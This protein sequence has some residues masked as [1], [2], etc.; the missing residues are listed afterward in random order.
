MKQLNLKPCTHEPNLYFTDDY[1]G[2]GKRVLFLRQVDDF[3]IA[4]QDTDL[5]NQVIKDINSKMSIEVKHLGQVERFNGVDIDQRRE[6]VKIHNTTYIDKLIQQ[7]KWLQDDTGTSHHHP[8]PMNPS[9]QYI[10]ELESAQPLTT[11]EKQQL[12]KSLN[13]GYR[14]AVGEIIYAMITCRPDISFAIIKLSQYSARPAKIHYDALISLYQYLKHTKTDGIYYWRKRPRMDLQ[15]GNIPVLLHENNYS[16]QT[17]NER[18][19][20]NE[21]IIR[22]YVDSDHASDSAHRKSISG[23]HCQLAGGVVLYKTQVQSIVAQSSTEAEFIAAA[24]A[25]KNILYLRTI[26][27]EI[28]LEQTDAN[29]L[30]EDNQGA[31]L[32]AKAGQPTKRTKH[33]DIKHFA[34]QSWVEQDL[35]TMHRIATCDNPADILTKATARSLF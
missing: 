26:M 1:N 8:I 28:G 7:H 24:E 21:K 2:T 20:E 25:G 23:F 22:T 10:K 16:E 33:I 14:Q 6:Y 15:K 35:I 5:A 19:C 31:L 27:Q 11:D 3:A 30:Y 34:L 17:V 9:P 29:I 18:R 12:E 13:F 32:M 4:C